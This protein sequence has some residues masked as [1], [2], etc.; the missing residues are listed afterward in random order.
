MARTISS[1]ID[2]TH[3]RHHFILEKNRLKKYFPFLNCTLQGNQL[4]CRGSITPS[5]GCCTYKIKFVY[6]KGKTP[7]VYIVNPPIEPHSKYHVY[8]DGSLCLFD[9]RVA[10]WSSDM[11]AHETIIPWTAE[12]LVFYELWKDTGTWQGAE[13]PHEDDEMDK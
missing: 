6:K 11:M 12:W 7:Q 13:A 1:R 4:T 5:E 2:A 8:K 3:R 9:P 10:S